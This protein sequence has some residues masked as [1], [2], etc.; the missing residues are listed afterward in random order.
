MDMHKAQMGNPQKQRQPRRRAAFGQRTDDQYEEYWK[1]PRLLAKVLT[2]KTKA[3][4]CAFGDEESSAMRKPK[5]TTCLFNF[6]IFV[7]SKASGNK[8]EHPALI[9]GNILIKLPVKPQATTQAKLA[10]TSNFIGISAGAKFAKNSI[11]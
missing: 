1:Q 3:C 8:N 7:R 10:I 4:G 6:A 5:G 2:P 9:L 11:R